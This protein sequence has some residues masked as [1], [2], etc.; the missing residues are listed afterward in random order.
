MAQATKTS[1][2]TFIVTV[3]EL[4]DMLYATS[5][6]VTSTGTVAGSLGYALGHIDRTIDGNFVGESLGITLGA[7]L[8]T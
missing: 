6:K 1:I 4:T 8:G 3:T 5:K 2:A 7:S